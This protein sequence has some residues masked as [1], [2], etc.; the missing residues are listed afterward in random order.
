MRKEVENIEYSW[1]ELREKSYKVNVLTP[2]DAP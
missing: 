1:L 2:R